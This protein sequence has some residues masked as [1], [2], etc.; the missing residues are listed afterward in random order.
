MNDTEHALFGQI[1]INTVDSL[2]HLC[3]YSNTLISDSNNCMMKSSTFDG[4]VKKL[5]AHF[6]HLQ[7]SVLII[8]LEHSLVTFMDF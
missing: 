2:K 1:N 5:M 3:N 8:I 7:A 4:S 6:G